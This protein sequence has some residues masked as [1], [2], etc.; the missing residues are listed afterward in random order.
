MLLSLSELRRLLPFTLSTLGGSGTKH[1]PQIDQP[2]TATV[3]S[4]SIK[5]LDPSSCHFRQLIPRLIPQ[6]QRRDLVVDAV[7]FT[8]LA[9]LAPVDT[10]DRSQPLFLFR[11][12]VFSQSSWL[13][14]GYSGTN[15]YFRKFLL[16][17][18]QEVHSRA[19]FNHLFHY[20]Y[21]YGILLELIKAMA[22]LV[23]TS[24]IYVALSS[25]ALGNLWSA[26]PCKILA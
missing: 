8:D 6:E 19:L 4:H 10:L 22:K 12:S 18:N 2:L 3:S 11:T 13:D 26:S 25:M 20:A 15:K 21:D 7:W 24:R 1:Q 16:V 14:Y 17:D 9:H 5:K 23:I